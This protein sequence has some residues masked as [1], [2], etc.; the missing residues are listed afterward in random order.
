MEEHCK[1]QLQ[2][3]VIETFTG[4]Y[5]GLSESSNICAAFCPSRKDE[6]ISPLMTEE[7]SGKEAVEEPPKLILKPLPTKL[8]PSAIA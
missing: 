7:G 1:K 8:N 6:V 4:F 2:E 3:E 5:E